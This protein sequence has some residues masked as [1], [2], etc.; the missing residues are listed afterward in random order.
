MGTVTITR[1]IEVDDLNDVAA[2]INEQ[3]TYYRESY[4][5]QLAGRERDPSNYSL[6]GIAEAKHIMY[7]LERA[8]RIVR[9]C[10]LREPVDG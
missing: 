9:D 6:K 7:G 1:I 8:E 10:K 3:I 5:S 2:A 4:E